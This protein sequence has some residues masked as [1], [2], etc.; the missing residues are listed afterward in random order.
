MSDKVIEWAREA[1]EHATKEADKSCSTDCD[2]YAIAWTF[3][4]NLHI[5]TLARADMK[6]QCAKH[7]ERLSGTEWFAENVADEIRA[8]K[9]Q[10]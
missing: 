1:S 5:S 6:E 2:A 7:F 9:D 10:T 8:L 3:A 4:F